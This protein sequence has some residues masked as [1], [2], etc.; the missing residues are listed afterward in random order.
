MIRNAFFV[1]PRDDDPGKDEDVYTGLHLLIH[2]AAIA[3]SRLGFVGA[4]TRVEAST[5]QYPAGKCA[6]AEILNVRSANGVLAL[7]DGICLSVIF[8][9]SAWSKMF[10]WSG[11]VA[12]SPLG[13]SIRLAGE[14]DDRALIV[15]L[16]EPSAS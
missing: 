4:F 6:R 15:E 11:N 13:T 12:T 7:W 1:K 9:T 5:N 2:F 16:M 8:L 10:G 3:F 14:R